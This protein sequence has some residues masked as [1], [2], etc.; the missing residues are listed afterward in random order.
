MTSMDDKVVVIF[1]KISHH[2]KLSI[3]YLIQNLFY[4]RKQK[5]ALSLSLH[6]IVLF[7]NALM[8]P[9]WPIRRVRCIQVEVHL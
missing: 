6:Y 9:K 4:N 1:T 3:V 8:Q 2:R 7:K 5:R